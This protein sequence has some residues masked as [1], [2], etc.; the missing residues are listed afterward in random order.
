MTALVVH[1]RTVD[2]A[3]IFCSLGNVTAAVIQTLAVEHSRV[4][5]VKMKWIYVMTLSMT[6]IPYTHAVQ[7]LAPV[8]IYV[9]AGR[10]GTEME[11]NALT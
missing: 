11:K 9:A 7:Q 1:V 8:L 4:N 2:F 5:T 10:D 6:V 3:S